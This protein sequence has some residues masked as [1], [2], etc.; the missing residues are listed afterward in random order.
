LKP[1]KDLRFDGRIAMNVL[2]TFWVSRESRRPA[3]DFQ[4]RHNEN[5][6]REPDGEKD[7][8]EDENFWTLHLKSPS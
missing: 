3:E 5:H 6:E 2:I 8:R 1:P 4:S 7:E